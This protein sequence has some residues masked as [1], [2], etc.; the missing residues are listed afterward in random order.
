MSGHKGNDDEG[1]QYDANTAPQAG[2]SRRIYRIHQAMFCLN[3][4]GCD[5]VDHKLSFCGWCHHVGATLTVKNEENNKDTDTYRDM[6]RI[7]K[8]SVGNAQLHV[9]IDRNSSIRRH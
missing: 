6:N 8:P 5:Y 3:H 1:E 4:C 9:R 7:A 2:D